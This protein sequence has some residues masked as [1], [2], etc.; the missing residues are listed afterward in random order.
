MTEATSAQVRIMLLWGAVGGMLPTLGR[1][2]GTYGANFDA[3]P[4]ALLG[5]MIALGLYGIIGSVVARAIGNVEVRQCLFAGIAA[6]AIVVSVLAGAS[7]AARNPAGGAGSRTGLLASA[8]LAQEPSSP[9]AETPAP[10][11]KTVTFDTVVQGGASVD[12]SVHITAHGGA[13]GPMQIGT[14]PVRQSNQTFSVNVPESTN[15]ISVDGKQVQLAP[16]GHTNL[17]LSITP[18]STVGTDFLWA[19][20]AKR[21]FDIG[22]IDIQKK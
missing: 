6:P 20:G 11:S 17:T 12:G 16:T 7:D 8:A 9:G 14:F 5:V 13:G 1:I 15:A 10:Q 18:K 19:L 2:A 4:P 22:K 21:T 3:P